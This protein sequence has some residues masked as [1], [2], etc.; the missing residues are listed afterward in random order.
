MSVATIRFLEAFIS[1]T[2]FVNSSSGFFILTVGILP[3]TFVASKPSVVGF[4]H[5]HVIG[6]EPSGSIV[7]CSEEPTML[8]LSSSGPATQC[9]HIGKFR[10]QLEN[11]ARSKLTTLIVSD[12]H[13]HS[14]GSN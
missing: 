13:V 4:V 14:S 7:T 3:A 9:K 2:F 12:S 5:V 11:K 1:S 10:K 8:L 6:E